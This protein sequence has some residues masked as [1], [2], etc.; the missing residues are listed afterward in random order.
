MHFDWISGP[1]DRYRITW[2]SSAAPA[3]ASSVFG[4]NIRLSLIDDMPAYRQHMQRWLAATDL[5][6]LSDEDDHGAR[7]GRTRRRGA[8]AEVLPGRKRRRIS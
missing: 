1:A 2:V 7:P 8:R 5:L 6:K 3:G 4:Q